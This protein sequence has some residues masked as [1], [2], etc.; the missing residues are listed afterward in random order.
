MTAVALLVNGPASQ[1]A[2]EGRLW[3]VNSPLSSLA[4]CPRQGCSTR[5]DHQA[6]ISQQE[7]GMLQDTGTGCTLSRELYPVPSD[8]TSPP[9][10][11]S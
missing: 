2:P 4:H 3:E 1:P 6:G 8:L 7:P 10:C 5:E 11:H 9:G